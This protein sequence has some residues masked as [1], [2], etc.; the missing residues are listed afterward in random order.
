MRAALSLARRGLGM[1]WPNPA[2]GCIIVRGGAVVGRGWT[3]PGGRPHAEAE[4]L[5]RAGR[6]AR[7]ACAYVTLEPC[8]HQGVTPP[9]AQALLDAGIA[10]LVGA[11]EDPDPRTAGGGYARLRQAGVEVV[12]GILRAEAQA[13][14]A[15]FVMR[16]RDG[17]PLV[18]L[19]TATTLDGRIAA[20]SGRS[21]WITGPQA[22]ARG[23]LLRASHDAI[24]IGIGTALADAPALT[25]RIAGLEARS[26]VRI[27]VDTKLRLPLDS[28]LATTARATPTWIVTV[29]GEAKHAALSALGVDVIPVA[30]GDDG[31]PDPGAV[32]QALGARGITRLLV[33]GG[34][35][36]AGA[37]LQ[38]DLI[39]R[40]AW[41]RTAGVMGGDGIAAVAGYGVSDPGQMARFTRTARIA[42]GCD[43]LEEFERIRLRPCSPD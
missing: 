18:T 20:R 32:M 40:M 1:A 27:V 24:M 10:R 42:L 31:R 37:L 35:A 25:C 8:N 15:G 22:R 28:V 39:D 33:E 23:H 13:L 43:S 5:R 16:I 6:K 29:A 14:N 19:K 2:V 41:F 34:G 12:T 9:C 7:G 38:A 36:L 4:A 17:R 21:Q 30:A 3:R 26:P 11:C